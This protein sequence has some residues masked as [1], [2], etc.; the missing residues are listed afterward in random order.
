MR[1]TYDNLGA[2]E[3][4]YKM[5]LGIKPVHGTQPI[6]LQDAKQ[7]SELSN[8]IQS[9]PRVNQTLQGQQPQTPL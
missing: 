9:P 3:P 6:V 5:H 1:E 4:V 8:L 2:I 7:K